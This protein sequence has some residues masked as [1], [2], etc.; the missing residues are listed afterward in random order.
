M[1]D[2]LD[3][4]EEGVGMPDLEGF[5]EGGEGEQ[6]LVDLVGVFEGGVLG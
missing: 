4:G 3:V 1:G 5:G 6:R 2:G